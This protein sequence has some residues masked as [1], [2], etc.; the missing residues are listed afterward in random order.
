MTSHPRATAATRA[1]AFPLV[2]E[3]DVALQLLLTDENGAR[4]IDVEASPFRI[5]RSSENHLQLAADSQI[6]RHQA[7]IVRDGDLWHIVDCSSRS[8][9]FLNGERIERALIHPGDRL[10]M[11]VT[12]LR[13]IS[14][15]EGTHT[16]TPPSFDFRQVNALLKGLR[17]LGS[18]AVLE[19]VLTLV[20]D[21]ALEMT[22]AERGFILLADDAGRLTSMLARQRGGLTLTGAKTSGRIPEEVFTTGEDRIVT[23]LRDEAWAEQHAGTLALGIRHI[24]CTPLNAVQFGAELSPSRIGVLYL[25]SR[26]RG[27][28]QH[29]AALHVL[30]AEAAV[31]IENARLYRE[32]VQKE[33]EAHELWIAAGIQQALLPPPRYESPRVELSAASVPCLAVGGDLFEYVT[34]EHGDFAFTVAD[35]VGKG[36]AAALLTAVVQGLLTAEADTGDSP[37]TVLTRVNRALCRRAIDGRFVTAFYGVLAGEGHLRYCNAGHN[38]PLLLSSGEAR[39]LDATGCP[40]GLFDT[41]AFEPGAVPIAPDDLLVLY[42]D[43]VTEAT[44][45]AGEEFGDER[46]LACLEAARRRPV[47]DVLRAIQDAVKS[48]AGAAPVQDDITIMVLRTR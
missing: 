7:E 1:D 47:D 42:S 32:V 26:E 39:K 14:S 25:D 41:G 37:D 28:L 33:R 12:E 4:R 44:N 40:L 31:V 30:A 24:L 16:G 46:L 11:G 9:T 17:G 29:A 3:P 10:R 20:L 34:N 15:D 13:V 36:T 38:P 23:D 35:V 43:G 8:G 18:S 48:F 27:Y 19:E 22:G 2:T 45:E 5:G 21:S 6:S